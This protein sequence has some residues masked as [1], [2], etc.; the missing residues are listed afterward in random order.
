MKQPSGEE[1]MSITTRLVRRVSVLATVF[2]LCALG[3]CGSNVEASAQASAQEVCTAFQMGAGRCGGA[4]DNT[5]CLKDMTCVFGAYRSDVASI[6]KG[7]ADR[8]TGGQC[9]MRQDYLCEQDKAAFAMIKPTVKGMEFLSAFDAKS[10]S[11]SSSGVTLQA[12]LASGAAYVR[13]EIVN[14]LSA[15]LSKACPEIN[16]CLQEAT[17]R[18][19]PSCS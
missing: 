3:G 11:C 12:D 9:P 2:A 17:M 6:F 16:G 8:Y 7:C 14:E 4:F 15:C 10:S 5:E 18:T 13:D 1:R 19:A